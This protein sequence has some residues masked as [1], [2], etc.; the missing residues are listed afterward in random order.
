[1]PERYRQPFWAAKALGKLGGLVGGPARARKLTKGQRVA[2]AKMGAQARL[3]KHGKKSRRKAKR[4][5]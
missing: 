2:I 1:M 3:A 4:S 5:G